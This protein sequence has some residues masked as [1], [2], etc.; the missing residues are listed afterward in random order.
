MRCRVRERTGRDGG[1][2]DGP[3]S[4][5]H[6]RGGGDRTRDCARPRPR[7]RGCCRE[8]PHERRCGPDARVETPGDGCGGPIAIRA[9]VRREGQVR[10]LVDTAAKRLEGL[11]ILV[12]NAG[13]YVVKNVEELSYAAWRD[14]LDSNVTATFLCA[15][16]AI[17]R[18]RRRGWGRI[19]SLGAAGAYRAHGS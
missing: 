10:H 17:P 9:D 1:A 5:R 8:L 2:V 16:Y 11:D 12:N 15:K 19:V 13:N 6:G 7:G 18:M 4:S 14:L 3:Q